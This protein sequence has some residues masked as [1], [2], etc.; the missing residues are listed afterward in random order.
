MTLVEDH[1][2][3]RK[4]INYLKKIYLIFKIIFLNK[5]AN[6]NYFQ[7]V[8]TLSSITNA[9]NPY[10]IDNLFYI[11]KEFSFNYFNSFV[12]NLISNRFHLRLCVIDLP[13]YILANIYFTIISKNINSKKIFFLGFSF[14]YEI[15]FLMHLLKLY[16]YKTNFMETA[17]ILHEFNKVTCKTLYLKYELSAITAK[18]L[19]NEE[20]QNYIFQKKIKINLTDKLI[21]DIPIIFF[22]SGY[23]NRQDDVYNKNYLIICAEEELN[24][25]KKID[26]FCKLSNRNYYIAPHYFRKAEN[27]KK[28]N[29][30]FIKQNKLNGTLLQEDSLS[31]FNDFFSITYSS[32]IFIEHLS[33][34][35]PAIIIDGTFEQRKFL[36]TYPIKHFYHQSKKMSYQTFV[37]IINSRVDKFYHP[38][39]E[40]K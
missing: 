15:K 7:K 27:F 11:D 5:K 10:N 40:I 8:F 30:Y 23:Y 33:N 9:H 21:K 4:K 32:N 26:E 37:N 31:K 35:V 6:N 19:F 38:I 29:E 18:N 36:S 12:K 16:N 14:L 24:S 3:S 20:S 28:A 25:I 2:L 39:S 13:S 22:T 1:R 17:S 34:F